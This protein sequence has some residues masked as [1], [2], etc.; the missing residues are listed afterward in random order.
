[1]SSFKSSPIQLFQPEWEGSR[2]E[3]L[4]LFQPWAAWGARPWA[5]PTGPL[6]HARSR[7]AAGSPVRLLVSCCRWPSFCPASKSMVAPPWAHQPPGGPP[8]LAGNVSFSSHTRAE[9]W[10]R[11]TTPRFHM[12]TEPVDD[13]GNSGTAPVQR[14]RVV[15]TCNVSTHGRVPSGRVVAPYVIIALKYY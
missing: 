8:P 6:N 10:R 14:S 12:P 11:S 13:G 3:R 15:G 2:C 9:K 4:S 5:G 1:M 7:V